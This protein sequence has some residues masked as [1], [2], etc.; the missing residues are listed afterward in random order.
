MQSRGKPTRQTRT[1]HEPGILRYVAS[2][3][4]RSVNEA[5]PG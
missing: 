5:N 4:T 1:I 2:I 3:L